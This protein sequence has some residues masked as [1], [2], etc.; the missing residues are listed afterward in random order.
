MA[1]RGETEREK[2]STGDTLFTLSLA[3]AVS[4]PMS[5]PVSM[6]DLPEGW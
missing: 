3:L 1:I 5:E 2:S 6:I 4:K